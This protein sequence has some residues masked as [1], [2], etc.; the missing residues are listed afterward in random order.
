MTLLLLT[1]F[2]LWA[3]EPLPF[4]LTYPT[5]TKSSDIEEQN[6]DKLAVWIDGE[7]YHSS[8]GHTWEQELTYPEFSDNSYKQAVR[9]FIAKN[10]QIEPTAISKDGYGHMNVDG[11]EYWIRLS[12]NSD[13]YSYILQRVEAAADS[14]SFDS[15]TSYAYTDAY[16]KRFGEVAFAKNSVLPH[17]KE[18]AISSVKYKKYDEHTFYYDGGHLH[19]G[20]YWSLDYKK[21]TKEPN[22]DR[23]SIAHDYKKKLLGLGASV[24]EDKDNTIKFRFEEDGQVNIIEFG[25]SDSGFSITIIREESFK[26]SLVL[27]PDSIKSALDKEGK[28]TLDGIY[29]DFNKATLKAESDKAILSTAA[30]M[31]T[32]SDLLLSVHGHTD[33]KGSD[34]YNLKLSTDRAASVRDAIIAKGIESERLLSKGHG[35]SEPIATNDTDE[36]RAQNRRVE[37]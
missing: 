25:G 26:Q 36:G 14:V 18:Y 15:N 7:G 19:K 5:V 8:Y 30:L 16:K 9:T 1:P 2:L 32:Y 20:E 27:T 35:E 6:Y 11:K 10:L 4:E 28:V 22:S 3:S 37:R 24:L 12:I 29:F 21:S 13:S 31:Q 33:A 23:Y 34:S 17:V